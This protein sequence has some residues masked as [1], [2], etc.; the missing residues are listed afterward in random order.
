[1]SGFN[2][3]Q[4]HDVVLL[5]REQSLLRLSPIGSGASGLCKAHTPDGLRHKEAR[6][7][8]AARRARKEYAHVSPCG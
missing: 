4:Q 7:A 6:P 3:T 2:F 8:G 1:V 5:R